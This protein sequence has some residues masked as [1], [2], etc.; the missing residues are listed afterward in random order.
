MEE[1]GVSYD[2]LTSVSERLEDL[3]SPKLVTDSGRVV[4]GRVLTRV[5]LYQGMGR[6]VPR[7]GLT[8]VDLYQGMFDAEQIDEEGVTSVVTTT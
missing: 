2:L 8:R 7:R 5:D 1:F 6:L 3:V 4:P